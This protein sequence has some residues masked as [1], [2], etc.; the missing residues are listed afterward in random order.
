MAQTPKCR[1]V[2][3]ERDQNDQGVAVRH[4]LPQDRADDPRRLEGPRGAEDQRV[5]TDVPA[6]D[7]LRGVPRD[8]IDEAQEDVLALR[9]APAVLEQGRR[10]LESSGPRGRGGGAFGTS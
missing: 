3:F 8:A 1:E 4:E 10:E 2:P 7:E 9:R 5:M 6:V